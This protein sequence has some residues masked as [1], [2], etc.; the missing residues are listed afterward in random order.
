MRLVLFV[1]SLPSI[2]T[3][4]KIILHFLQSSLSIAIQDVDTRISEDAGNYLCDF[5][6]YTSLAHRYKQHRL[7]KAMFLHVPVEAD[8]RSIQKGVKI[9]TEL[10]RAMVECDLKAKDTAADNKILKT[11]KVGL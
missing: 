7:N 1:L 2:F 3:D 10:I 9:T 4:T 6:Y 5:I 11:E 8:H